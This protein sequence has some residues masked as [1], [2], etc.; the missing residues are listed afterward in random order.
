MRTHLTRRCPLVFLLLLSLAAYTLAAEFP[1][2][3]PGLVYSVERDGSGP[4]AVFVLKVDRARTEYRLVGTLA[5]DAVFGLE[6]VP[7]QARRVP[8]AV[9]HP[10]AAINGDWFELLPGPYQGDLRDLLVRGGELISDAGPGNCFWLDPQGQPHLGPVTTDLQVTWPDGTRTLLGLN[11]ARQDNEAVL[12]TPTL[13]PSTHTAGGR[14]LVL[15]RAGEGPW[16]PLR[17]GP[18]L[19][20]RVREVREAGD[21]PL[22]PATVVLSLGPALAAKLPALPPGAS[23]TLAAASTPDLTGVDLALGGGQTLLRA[24]QAPDFG[25]GDLPRHPRSVFGW[26][27]THY[28]L[29][30]VDGP[31]AGWSA[32]MTLPEL[33]ALALRLGCTD[34]LNLD[35]GGS[36]T[37]WLHDQVMNLPSDGKPRE[38]GNALVVVRTEP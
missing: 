17:I 10:V 25:A 15:E 38:V 2:V 11:R 34:A 12:Y 1:E 28:F 30:V 37:L 4:E 29:I 31:R 6:T 18:P 27:A 21:T 5:K 8:E 36:S 22:T 24:G 14:E 9:G 26:N 20:A 3:P 19:A 16:L 32:G 33:S 35:G 23:V 13:G 7:E